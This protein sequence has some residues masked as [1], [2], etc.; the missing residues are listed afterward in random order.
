MEDI[1]DLY[2]QPYDPLH[3]V[4][5]MDERPC[6]LIDDV[7]VPIPMKPGKPRKRDHEY[8][9]NGTCCILIAFEPKT[10]KRFIQRAPY[11]SGLCSIY[12]RD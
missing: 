4:I 1:L 6:Q 3:P 5:C 2:E 9:R 8:R 11:K 12:E 10:G 7:I